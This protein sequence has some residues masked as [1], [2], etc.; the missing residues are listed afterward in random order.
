MGVHPSI[1]FSRSSL[2]SL[3]HPSIPNSLPVPPLAWL[4][5]PLPIKGPGNRRKININMVNE[6]MK[7][8]T[9]AAKQ[10]LLAA[11]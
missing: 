2:T 6:H 11:T 10:Q 8:E 1:S 4:T 5:S 9:T 7:V 3:Y